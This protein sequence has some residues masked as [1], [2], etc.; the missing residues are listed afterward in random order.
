M[1]HRSLIRD[2]C[3]KFV[4]KISGQMALLLLN[5]QP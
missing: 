3:A 5:F 2:K 4:I 1:I